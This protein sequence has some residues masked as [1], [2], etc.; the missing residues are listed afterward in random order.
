MKKPTYSYSLLM[1]TILFLGLALAIPGTANAKWFCIHGHSGQI[2]D[3]SAL[4][5]STR[6]GWGLIGYMKQDSNTWV[7][8]AVPSLKGKC[9]VGSIR[10]QYYTEGTVVTDLAVYNGGAK[11]LEVEAPDDWKGHGWHH[12]E[13]DCGD[14]G[15]HPIDSQ[16]GILISARIESKYNEQRKFIF[17]SAQAEFYERDDPPLY[18]DLVQME[19]G[20]LA[21]DLAAAKGK[22]RYSSIDVPEGASE[23]AFEM[24]G[25]TGDA[26]IYVRYGSVPTLDD[27]DYQSN[28]SGN[29]D[30]IQITSPAPGVWHI[31]IFAYENFAGATLK[32]HYLGEP[33][34]EWGPANRICPEQVRYEIDGKAAQTPA[35]GQP[36]PNMS[37]ECI[38]F[39][40]GWY[41]EFERGVVVWHPQIG[42]HEIHGAI[43]DHWG[44]F[45]NPWLDIGY[46]ISDEMSDP[47]FPGSRF[48]TFQHATIYWSKKTGA[49]MIRG[50][51]FKKWNAD[52]GFIN[53]H[54]LGLPIIDEKVGAEMNG[55]YG[56]YNHFQYGSIY[57]HPAHGAFEVHGAIKNRY[58]QLKAEKSWLGYPRSDET[59]LKSDTQVRFSAFTN[60]EIYFQSSVGAKETNGR[61]FYGEYF[62]DPSRT[63]HYLRWDE[64]RGWIQQDSNLAW[65]RKE[66]AMVGLTEVGGGRCG[67]SGRNRYGP[68]DPTSDDWCT[69]FAARVFKWS[70]MNDICGWFYKYWYLLAPLHECMHEPPWETGAMRAIFRNQGAWYN[71]STITANTASVGDYINIHKGDH[72]AIIVAVSFDRRHIWIVEGNLGDCVSF[73]RRAYWQNGKLDS[74][75]F[76]IGKIK[77]DFFGNIGSSNF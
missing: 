3:E 6:A 77:P 56:A 26:D 36:I 41:R 12:I 72:S 4:D 59:V 73:R 15:D 11:K 40:G 16:R 30:T 74:D 7:H 71:R 52:G 33:D 63:T 47:C 32:A 38:P 29:D 25:G 45:S 51:I 75:I 48:N 57:W 66:I 31:M 23:L 55:Q 50:E 18:F 65:Y 43:Y 20:F 39:E 49:H 17:S 21:S 14:H 5:K 76:G 22:A 24:Y 37:Y 69:E 42:T 70:G 8:F 9:A 67:V 60:G 19:D 28:L 46:P 2:E 44:S 68:V 35:L 58:D 27:W 1:T 34:F 62:P 10:L 54:W 61:I 13:V 64:L 53:G